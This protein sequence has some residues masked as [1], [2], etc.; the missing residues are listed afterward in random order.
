MH[1]IVGMG[2]L[3]FLTGCATGNNASIQPP[4]DHT[5]LIRAEI[6]KFYHDLERFGRL[7]RPVRPRSQKIREL[8]PNTLEEIERPEP[9]TKELIQRLNKLLQ[10]P[11]FKEGWKDEA[12]I[13]TWNGPFGTFS[14]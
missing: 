2:I 5:Q 13:D 10:D 8:D 7:L 6:I 11:K 9:E 3:V 14:S 12:I 1:R 4:V